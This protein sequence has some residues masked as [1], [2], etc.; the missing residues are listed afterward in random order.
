MDA[1]VTS[2][3]FTS[4]AGVDLDAAR[5]RA[6]CIDVAPVDLNHVATRVTDPVLAEDPVIVLQ[7]AQRGGTDSC[8]ALDLPPVHADVEVGRRRKDE[9]DAPLFR[10]LRLQVRIAAGQDGRPNVLAARNTGLR[11]AAGARGR[12]RDV[13]ARA[14][15]GRLGHAAEELGEIGHLEAR[16]VGTS[17]GQPIGR[18][19]LE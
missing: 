16:A 14:N 18:L 12:V 9:T 17:Q 19:P 7:L 10:F 3:Q 13:H 2:K 4:Q 6:A 1:P 5:Q 15:T 11:I 8:Q